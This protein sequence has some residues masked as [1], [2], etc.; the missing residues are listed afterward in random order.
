MILESRVFKDFSSMKVLNK[1]CGYN[2]VMPSFYFLLHM[3]FL[4]V[5]NALSIRTLAL[6]VAFIP[7]HLV[8]IHIFRVPWEMPWMATDV[9]LSMMS[10]QNT[11]ATR[12]P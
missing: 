3:D 2:L 5:T 8:S 12:R 9:H 7:C 4:H 1:F 11:M 10:A 6:E